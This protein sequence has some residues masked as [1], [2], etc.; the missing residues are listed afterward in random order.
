[1]RYHLTESTPY[2]SIAS[3]GSAT[4]PLDFDIFDLFIVQCAWA[5]TCLGGERPAAINI[6]G[7]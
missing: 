6:A 1:M 3:N 7:Q 4:L 5:M 2:L